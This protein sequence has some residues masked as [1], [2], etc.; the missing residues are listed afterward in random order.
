MKK[1][2]PV[3]LVL[4]LVCMGCV[5]AEDEER[6]CGD[7]T[8]VL[9]S[10]GTAKLKWYLGAEKHLVLPETLDGYTVTGTYKETFAF[11]ESIKTVTIPNN[12]EYFGFA[13][14]DNCTNLSAFCVAADHP[15]FSVKDGVLFDR[16][17]ETLLFYPYGLTDDSYTVPDGV[18]AIGERAFSSADDLQVVCL[19]DSVKHIGDYAFS[20]CEYLYDVYL[21][22]YMDSIGEGAFISTALH[23]IRIP[24]GVETIEDSTFIHCRY[25]NTVCLPDSLKEICGNPFFCDSKLARIKL[26]GSHP[27]FEMN[28]SALIDKSENRL[29]CLLQNYDSNTYALPEGLRVIGNDSVM[30]HDGLEKLVLP[31]GVVSIE[32]GAFSYCLDLKEIVLPDSVRS[33]GDNAFAHCGMLSRLELPDDLEYI[34]EDAF[35]RC[36]M[37]KETDLRG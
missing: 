24:E 6:S 29:V 14:F 10:D 35:F 1:L 8:Y 3:I 23:S 36:D 9:Q 32:E 21:P 31:D 37:L 22:Q 4:V 34:G 33:I 30:R 20:G 7:Y 13:A 25:L 2:L 11:N 15:A 19:P 5:L 27:V 28:G 18:K 12:Y 17:G 26:S 16:E